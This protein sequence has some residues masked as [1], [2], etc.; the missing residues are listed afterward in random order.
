MGAGFGASRA[1][2]AAY[3]CT[4]ARRETPLVGLPTLAAAS[5]AGFDTD[6]RRTVSGVLGTGA[7]VDARRLFVDAIVDVLSPRT[8]TRASP[9]SAFIRKAGASPLG[10][11]A[12]RRRTVMT[13]VC[14]V[15]TDEGV[16]LPGACACGLAT[17]EPASSESCLCSWVSSG[18]FASLLLQTPSLLVIDTKRSCSKAL[19][20]C[21]NSS[22]ADAVLHEAAAGTGPVDFGSLGHK[23]LYLHRMP[24]A[25]RKTPPERLASYCKQNA[26]RNCERIYY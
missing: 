11:I 1:A 25:L 10:L 18:T 23:L 20:T 22:Y 6:R 17:A 12:L 2:A 8:L 15:T 26:A 19:L 21:K 4:V 13:D 16:R 9:P 24:S 3:A 14:F 5:S 7:I